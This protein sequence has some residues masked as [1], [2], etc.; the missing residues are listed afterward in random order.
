MKPMIVVSLNSNTSEMGDMY[1][2]YTNKIGR[3]V[4]DPAKNISG[5]IAVDC[6]S[7]PLIFKILSK[8]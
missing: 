6:K 4:P 8:F 2:N 3:D 5:Q 7:F 1:G